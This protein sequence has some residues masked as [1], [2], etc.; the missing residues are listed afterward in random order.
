MKGVCKDNLFLLNNQV[1]NCLPFYAQHSDRLAM[2]SLWLA[3]AGQAEPQKPTINS[4]LES[5]VARTVSAKCPTGMAICG[6]QTRV[7]PEYG[8]SAEDTSMNDLRIRC[9][10][11]QQNGG[12]G[13]EEEGEDKEEE[14]GD[15]GRR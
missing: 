14:E 2:V 15:D 7:A 3:C 8:G 9:C 13:D 11:P 6:L 4:G 12:G 5:R 10:L 1:I